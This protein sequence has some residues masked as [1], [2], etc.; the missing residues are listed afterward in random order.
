MLDTTA[1]LDQIVPAS[2][3]AAVAYGVSVLTRTQDEAANATVRLGQRLIGR[4]LNRDA[5]TAPDSG[6]VRTAVVRLAEAGAD[7]D[8]LA[9]RRAELRIALRTA[10]TDTP[11][12]AEELSALLPTPPPPPAVHAEG[13]RSVAVG[14]D[15]SGS[16]STGDGAGGAPRQ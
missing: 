6:P 13:E 3:A 8:V 10:L 11:G 14:G 2:E 12:L 4:L 1:L 15:N 16:I 9:L 7:P 5:D